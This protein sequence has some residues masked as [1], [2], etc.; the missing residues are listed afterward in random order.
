VRIIEA[1]KSDGWED[2]I[3][4]IKSCEEYDS[5]EERMEEV[6]TALK[7]WTL[8]PVTVDNSNEWQESKLVCKSLIDPSFVNRLANRPRKESWVSYFCTSHHTVSGLTRVQQYKG[9]NRQQN[10]EKKRV[11]DAGTK[12]LKRGLL[13]DVVESQCQVELYFLVLRLTNHPTLQKKSSERQKAKGNSKKPMTTLLR[14]RAHQ[15]GQRDPAP[16]Q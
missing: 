6:V 7:V 9:S 15:S 16:N 1:H 14:A 3:T 2:G 5:F 10:L 11:I 4:P 8:L 13:E 12:A